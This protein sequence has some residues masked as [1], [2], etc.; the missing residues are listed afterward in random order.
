MEVAL[1]EKWPHLHSLWFVLSFEVSTHK[2][3]QAN[4][5]ACYGTLELTKVFDNEFW[6]I[7]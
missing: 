4:M 3:V 6:T 7:E 5:T 1:N 2:T